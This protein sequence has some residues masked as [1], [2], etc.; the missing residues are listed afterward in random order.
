M[1]A[2]VHACVLRA[3]A[4]RGGLLMLQRRAPVDESRCDA[5]ALMM[6]RRR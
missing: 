4:R 6:L 5:V 2:D 3:R 1:Q